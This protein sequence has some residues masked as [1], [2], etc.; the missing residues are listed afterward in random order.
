MEMRQLNYFIALAEETSVSRAAVKLSVAQ[1]AISRQ[2]RML[3]EELGVALFHRTGRGMKLTS[4]GRFFESRLRTILSDLQELEHDVRQ[5]KGLI[6]GK[7]VLG[8]P[9]TESHILVPRLL[10]SLR[11][12]H[13]GIELR[14]VEAFSGDVSELL[15]TGHIDVALFYKAPRT[16]HYIADELLHESLY[17]LQSSEARKPEE[18]PISVAELANYPLVLPSRRHGLRAL[19]DQ[20]SAEADVKLVVD[21]EVDSLLPLIRMVEDGGIA[22]ILPCNAVRREIEENRIIATQIDPQQLKR[23][24][25]LATTTHHPVR[26]AMKVVGQT[27]SDLVRDLAADGNW[28]GIIPRAKAS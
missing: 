14:I 9:P 19:L 10:R 16:R 2:I 6:E 8:L 18:E 20:V 7:V 3:E 17:L 12:S 26:A 15:T 23:T 13:P 24:L 27:C 21:Y 1:P 22:T 28:L 5:Q 25:V 4:A 11:Q